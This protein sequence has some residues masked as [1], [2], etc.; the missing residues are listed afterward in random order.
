MLCW[1]DVVLEGGGEEL[2]SSVKH[3]C[4][5]GILIK[6]YPQILKKIFEECPIRR[7]SRKLQ[8]FYVITPKWLEP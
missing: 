4:D 2:N 5:V 3:F 1:F 8:P 7:N 6:D